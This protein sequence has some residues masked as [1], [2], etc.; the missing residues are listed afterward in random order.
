[1]G[2]RVLKEIVEF[3]DAN[4][5]IEEY[6]IQDEVSN[7]YLHYLLK[8]NQKDIDGEIFFSTSTNKM[9]NNIVSGKLLDLKNLNLEMKNELKYMT[10]YQKGMHN[11]YL[12]KNEGL[13]GSS[14]YILT[15]KV[16]FDIENEKE[17][18]TTNI[19]K[20]LNNGEY[21]NRVNT[22]FEKA[23]EYLRE[24]NL[25]P[26]FSLQKYNSKEELGNIKEILINSLE[27][28]LINNIKIKDFLREKYLKQ[29]TGKK[30]V[31]VDIRIYLDVGLVKIID[32]Y[33]NFVKERAFLDK[34]LPIA[35]GECS[36]CNKYSNEL[37]LPYILNSGG[38]DFGMKLTMP[39]KLINQV[40]KECTLKLHKFKVMTDNNQLTK[41]FPLFIDKKNL[42]GKQKSILEDNEKK[43]SYH[44]IIKSI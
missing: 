33:N 43:K 39:L 44:E 34:N 1:L 21:I 37:S 40:C 20:S 8:I 36:I 23:I 24:N 6:F 4:N 30:I 5:G 29:K 12:D 16:L 2:G 25:Q 42:F 13:G 3:M 41:P 17:L 28:I 7:T 9:K 27:I 14:P 15:V 31:Y 11:K 35:E 19:I 22:Q 32:F 18:I 38:D 26:I 10:Y